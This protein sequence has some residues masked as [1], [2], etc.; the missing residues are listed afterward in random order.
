M[1]LKKM[2][3]EEVWEEGE[4]VTDESYILT[5]L[6]K[7]EE[8]EGWEEVKKKIVFSITILKAFAECVY[9]ARGQ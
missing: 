1:C 8:V 3:E 9:S 7:M 6:K 2:E 4:R 5:C